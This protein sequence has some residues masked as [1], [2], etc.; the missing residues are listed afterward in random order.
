MSEPRYS[1]L[2]VTLAVRAGVSFWIDG[3]LFG[4]AVFC[5]GGR[6]RIDT[7]E[8]KDVSNVLLSAAHIPTPKGDIRL[9]IHAVQ[10][11]TRVVISLD[12]PTYVQI[13]R[14]TNG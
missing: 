9:G 10:S 13:R 2:R 14:D 3:E 11:V 12:A 8:L 1:V 5:G 4:R 7:P 6:F